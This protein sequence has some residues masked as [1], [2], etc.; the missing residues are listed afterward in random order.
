MMGSLARLDDYFDPMTGLPT[1]GA[2]AQPEAPQDPAA[3]TADWAR[4]SGQH[5]QAFEPQGTQWPQYP[6]PP[7]KEVPEDKPNPLIPFSAYRSKPPQHRVG[8]DGSHGEE[9][10]RH[11]RPGF[12][13]RVSGDAPG[14][15][16]RVSSD[17]QD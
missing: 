4:I 3:F 17:A 15:G 11:G 5:P 2:I 1:G 13:L 14:F 6:P 9:R 8:Y 7:P 16:L 10:K 12:R